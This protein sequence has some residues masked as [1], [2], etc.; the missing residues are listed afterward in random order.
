MIIIASI[1]RHKIAK[2]LDAMGVGGYY[3]FIDGW[4]YTTM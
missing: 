2:L 1:Y 3:Y 4:G